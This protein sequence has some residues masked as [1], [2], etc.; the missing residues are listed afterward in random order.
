MD[1]GRRMAA[2][3]RQGRHRNLR[4]PVA[5]ALAFALF[6]TLALPGCGR[7]TPAPASPTPD[8]EDELV[9]IDPA[10]A[11][12]YDGSF[13]IDLLKA[14]FRTRKEQYAR[15]FQRITA[16]TSGY[17]IR[18][19]WYFHP[20]D[21]VETS[22]ADTDLDLSAA[23]PG[24]LVVF[25]TDIGIL[26][27]AKA[28]GVE[29]SVLV[30]DI[31]I[32]SRITSENRWIRM[33]A[34]LSAYAGKSVTLTL[35]T[36]GTPTNRFAWAGF[37]APAVTV[38]QSPEASAEGL[39]AEGRGTLSVGLDGAAEREEGRIRVTGEATLS[40]PDQDAAARYL[41]V[42]GTGSPDIE[43]RVGARSSR[44]FGPPGNGEDG[45]FRRVVPLDGDIRVRDDWDLSLGLPPDAITPMPFDRA[46]AQA[47]SLSIRIG[48]PDGPVTIERITLWRSPGVVALES[49]VGAAYRDDASRPVE[50]RARVR[51]D[52]QGLVLRDDGYGL[53]V[54]VRDAAGAIR[55]LPG[56]RVPDLAAGSVFQA[57]FSAGRLPEGEY[58][59]T[60]YWTAGTG[61]VELGSL[62][63]RVGAVMDPAAPDLSVHPFIESDTLRLVAVEEGGTLRETWLYRK[64]GESAILLGALA[65]PRLFVGNTR[66]RV[67][68][69]S[70]AERSENR[71]VLEKTVDAGRVRLAYQLDGTA[72]AA[73]HEFIPNGNTDLLA[74]D[75]PAFLAGAGSFGDRKDSAIFCGIDSL[76]REPSNNTL[77]IAAPHHLRFAPDPRK[78]THPLMSLAL[79]G[80]VLVYTWDDHAEWAPGQSFPVPHFEAPALDGSAWSRM[81]LLAPSGTRYIREN[82]LVAH[83]PYPLQAG[84]TVRLSAEIRVLDGEKAL[85]GLTD[86]LRRRTLPEP[87]ETDRTVESVFRALLDGHEKEQMGEDG[88]IG[89]IGSDPAPSVNLESIHTLLAAQFLL[90][91]A[92]ADRARAI[93]ASIRIPQTSFSWA[94]SDAIW[95]RMEEDRLDGYFNAADSVAQGIRS[96]QLDDGSFSYRPADAKGRLFG[97]AGDR[98]VGTVAVPV[99]HLVKH[100]RLTGNEDSWQAALRGLESL[101]TFTKPAGA[102][103]WELANSNP[104]ALAAFLG[105]KAAREAFEYRPDEALRALV[106]DMAASALPFLY[107]SDIP[108]KP[109]ALYTLVPSFGA[110][111]WM[112]TWQGSPVQWQGMFLAEEYKRLAQFDESQDWATL[113][114]GLTRAGMNLVNTGRQPGRFPDYLD[115][116]KTDPI[117]YNIWGNL[118][119]HTLLTDLGRKPG[120]DQREAGGVRVVSGYDIRSL[121]AS[122]GWVRLEVDVP[123]GMPCYLAIQ[124]DVPGVPVLGGETLPESGSLGSL[125]R[126]YRVSEAAGGLVVKIHGGVEPAVL[127]FGLAP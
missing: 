47:R 80:T 50:L 18:D 10:T 55:R 54:E 31:P 27:G 78:V 109:L 49:F 36:R 25:S 83:T 123:Q 105:L 101:G 46:S 17:V 87:P 3:D 23:R 106:A 68:G 108:N 52:G 90:P 30:N 84:E 42:E 111:N 127:E 70:L 118:V 61:R 45:R 93:L 89:F 66:L 48:A 102:G 4:M 39:P 116:P 117:V 95:F 16:F 44:S 107:L 2:K 82:E 77:A 121:E 114:E 75:G 12:P 33:E 113:A 79:D 24:S 126:G 92:D 125:D 8:P 38:V 34:D 63:R 43:A 72:L 119:A 15:S 28:D 122:S 19:S 120:W 6:L 58:T 94:Y 96:A 88:W 97:R 51:N 115:I 40:L 71:L 7:A 1:M 64:E 60:L 29:F 67:N 99:I 26:D 21:S 81:A 41:L 103:P 65:Q 110:T 86:D 11:L 20:H 56:R 35:G 5:L 57:S 32:L 85:D 37:G 112:R 74:F 59:F 53:L 98:T 62:V 22:Y 9:D 124:G 104:D 73:T 76:S 13:R 91:P 14:E 100:A 69:F